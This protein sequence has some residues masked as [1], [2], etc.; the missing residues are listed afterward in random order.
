MKN[1][2]KLITWMFASVLFL[3]SSCS[4]DEGEKGI[5]DN[6][7]R[8]D[9]KNYS[10]PFAFGMNYGSFE[11]EV[12]TINNT[13]FI[14][15]DREIDIEDEDAVFSHGFYLELYSIG[16]EDFKDGT[17]TYYSGSGSLPTEGLFEYAEIFFYD[18]DIDPIEVSGGKVEVTIS[19]SKYEFVFDMTTTDGKKLE[20]NFS[21]N[22][23]IQ[24]IGGPNISGNIS[25]D[26]VG[27]SADFGNIVDY[28]HDGSHYNYDFTIYDNSE[29]FELYFEAFS[30]GTS[31]FQAGTFN[32]NVFGSS[33]F[34]TIVYSDFEESIVFGAIGG[35]VVVTKLSG[36]YEYRL[37]FD[38]LLEDESELTGTVEGNF[39]Y[40][41]IGGREGGR[42]PLH[43]LGIQ[44]K[45]LREHSP[46]KVNKSSLTRIK[47][48]KHPDSYRSSVARVV[49]KTKPLL[50]DNK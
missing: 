33:H 30:L 47:K 18:E 4:K 31:G 22:I 42:F 20:G 37:V 27:K 5:P 39:E 41:G 49:E 25:K 40:Y 12:G 15:V 46:F 36:T 9:G 26:G 50:N 23:E 35:S 32:Y 11:S 29:T 10:V 14:F 1:Q 34:S 28:G 6:T 8:Y 17:F 21:G 7:I 48:S 2:L 38:V 24:N 16:S 3:F 13:D 44:T 43:N 19:G 45:G